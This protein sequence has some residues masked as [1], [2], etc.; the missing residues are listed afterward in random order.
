LVTNCHVLLV[1]DATCGI[2]EYYSWK[3]ELRPDRPAKG[4]AYMDLDIDGRAARG[5]RRYVQLISD[6][7]DLSGDGVFIELERPAGVYIAL[8]DRVPQFP[9]RDLA[10]TWDEEHG[11]AAGIETE[12]SDDLVVLSYLGSTVL[13]APGTVAAFV[14]QLSGDKCPGQPDPPAL[15][16][17]DD[18]D[19][20]AEQLAAYAPA[21]SA[22]PW[23][24]TSLPPHE[25]AADIELG[26]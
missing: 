18:I 15:R 2:A 17:A 8:E 1:V 14:R 25:H 6:A 22:R 13:P 7:L 20:L 23:S 11:W 21:N 16:A 12:T 26:R 10:L 24:I 19:D 3:L 4:G 5:L 9:T